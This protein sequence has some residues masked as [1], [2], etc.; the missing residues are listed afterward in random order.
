MESGAPIIIGHRLGI[1]F[2]VALFKANP[3][4]A[5]VILCSTWLALRLELRLLLLFEKS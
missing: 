3:S 1:R 4:L 2:V 5:L